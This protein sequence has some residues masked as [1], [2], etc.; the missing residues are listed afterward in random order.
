MSKIEISR[1]RV[2]FFFQSLEVK[3][4]PACYLKS[5]LTDELEG[6]SLEEVDEL[7]QTLETEGF[8]T[9]EAGLVSLVA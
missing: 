3:E 4:L 8:L 2:S 5:L 1:F 7:L 6:I 9:R